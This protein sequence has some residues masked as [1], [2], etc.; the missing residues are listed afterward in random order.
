MLL[1]IE[2][3]GWGSPSGWTVNPPPSPPQTP[4]SRAD[5]MLALMTQAE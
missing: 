2:G 1:S 3:C 5:A 4:D